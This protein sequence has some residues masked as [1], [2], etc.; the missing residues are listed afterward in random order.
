MRSIT[1]GIVVVALGLGLMSIIGIAADQAAV[2][3]G[4]GGAILILGAGLIASGML[5][6]NQGN[7]SS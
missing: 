1:L 4:V 3:I 2:G 7:P 6:R 5:R